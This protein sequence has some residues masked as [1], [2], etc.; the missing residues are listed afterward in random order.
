MTAL[1]AYYLWIKAA[2]IL[3]IISWMAGLLYL[4]R[5]FVYHTQV[6][7]G[8]EAD[9][10]FQTMERRLLRGIVN[11]AGTLVLITGILLLFTHNQMSMGWLHPKLLLVF[12]LFGCHGMMAKFRKDFARGQNQKSEKFYRIFNEVPTVLMIGIVILAVV[13]PF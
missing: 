10:K 4:P 7:N 8:S 3:S 11:P 6:E 2:H 1:S 5:L 12:I 13:K 9:D